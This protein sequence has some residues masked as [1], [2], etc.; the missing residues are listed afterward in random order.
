MIW[1]IILISLSIT[2]YC[3]YD[4]DMCDQ[5]VTDIMSYHITITLYYPSLLSLE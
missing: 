4:C 3:D 5:P 2:F 1:Y